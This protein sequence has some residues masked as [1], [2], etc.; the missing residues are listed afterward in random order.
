[1]IL[2]KGLTQ[3]YPSYIGPELYIA[4]GAKWK[5]LINPSGTKLGLHDYNASRNASATP[6]KHHIHK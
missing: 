5:V 6:H 2:F 3:V 4:N 1:M